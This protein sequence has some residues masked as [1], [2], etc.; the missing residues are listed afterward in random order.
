MFGKF[1]RLSLI[2]VSALFFS[3]SCE[4]Q[5]LGHSARSQKSSRSSSA[6][7]AA[8]NGRLTTFNQGE[9]S[10]FGHK[11]E[12]IAKLQEKGV[13]DLFSLLDSTEEA[14]KRKLILTELTQVIGPDDFENFI[15]RVEEVRD[16][17]NVRQL[18][19]ILGSSIARVASLGAHDLAENYILEKTGAGSFRGQLLLQLF[20]SSSLSL[21]ELKQKGLSLPYEEDR[22]LALRAVADHVVDR[23]EFE[24]S[25]LRNFLEELPEGSYA[26]SG[27]GSSL[28]GRIGKL[29]V[30]SNENEFS[31]LTL[32]T[33]S[34]IVDSSDDKEVVSSL[35]SSFSNGMRG[36]SQELWMSFVESDLVSDPDNEKMLE[37]LVSRM[38]SV[39][40]QK[41]LTM[42]L[43]ERVPS[44]FVQSGMAAWLKLDASEAS[45]WLIENRENMESI[46]T[47]QAISAIVE[48]SIK[49]HEF[50]RAASWVEQ[51]SD[52][53]LRVKLTSQ[54]LVE[55]NRN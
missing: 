27:L 46:Q 45:M 3:L 38:V 34:M 8:N 7:K 25:D 49:Y 28:A 33:I 39:E 18:E 48:Y 37:S 36:A 55:R 2:A 17:L 15:L 5:N 14:E 53:S 12:F 24:T 43:E 21:L 13:E 9:L 26:L 4:E 16:V 31:E 20:S 23:S 42:T 32:E 41:A 30:E 52:E 51:M 29:S 47:D 40:P 50:D 35:L 22:N 54:L 1:N 44:N 11:R 6:H 10:A 19:E